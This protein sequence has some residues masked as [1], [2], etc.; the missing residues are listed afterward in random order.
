[1]QQENGISRFII[2]NTT[3][4]DGEFIDDTGTNCVAEERKSEY[5][6]YST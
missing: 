1:M 6:Y 4:V 3:A 2:V 5:K